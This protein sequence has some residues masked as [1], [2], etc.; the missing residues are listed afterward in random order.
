MEREEEAFHRRIRDGYLRIAEQEER[1]VRID[2]ERR[3]EEVTD[4]ALAALSAVLDERTE[5]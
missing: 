2:G 1:V 4:A 3:P 5:V